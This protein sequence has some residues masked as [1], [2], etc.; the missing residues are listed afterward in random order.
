MSNLD[1]TYLRYIYDGL[2][3]GSVHLENA[4]ELPD[5]LIGLYEESFEE[6]VP[7]MHR[8]KLLQRFALFA[9]LKKEV[10]V[11]FVAEVLD[12]NEEDILDFINTYASWFNSP[13]PGK[14][15]LYHERLK[16][17]LLQ[18]LSEQEVAIL[19]DSIVYFLERNVKEEKVNESVLYCFEFLS[20]HLFFCAYLYGKKEPLAR[21]CLDD[22][23]KKRQFEI[24]GFYDWE[25]QLM[26]FGVQL[27]ALKG[28][29]ICH[30]IVF[31]KTKIQFKKKD[32]DLILSLIKR[33]K[34]SIVFRFFQT[35]QETNL[36][37]RIELAYFYIFSFYEIFE[38]KNFTFIQKK[39]IA[40]KLLEIFENNFQWD[41]GGHDL[42]EF[43]DVN[44]SFRLHCYFEQFGLNFKSIAI[45]CSS[46]S[47][48]F[49][50]DMNASF[51]E[52]LRF[53]GRNHTGEAKTILKDFKKFD[54]GIKDEKIEGLIYSEY[55]AFEL[56]EIN[57]ELLLK[58]NDFSKIQLIRDELA[59]SGCEYET[60]DELC[61]FI[62]QTLRKIDI[63]RDIKVNV[64]N[65]LKTNINVESDG[66]FSIKGLFENL[67]GKNTLE[68]VRNDFDKQNEELNSLSTFISGGFI[69]EEFLSLDIQNRYKFLYDETLDCDE[70]IKLM[71]L[72]IEL[73]EYFQKKKPIDLFSLL[74]ALLVEFHLNMHNEFI[75][76]YTN[77]LLEL[78]S[79]S[80][81]ENEEFESKFFNQLL[82][83]F[84]RRD[85]N[86]HLNNTLKLIQ[87]NLLET[88]FNF[89]FYN[90][91]FVAGCNLINLFSK[92][93]LD[94]A[95]MDIFNRIIEDL[96]CLIEENDIN[97]MW[98]AIEESCINNIYQK[99]YFW[100]FH[101]AVKRIQFELVR[102]NLSEYIFEDILFHQGINQKTV[103]FFR[104]NSTDYPEM[105]K[106][107][108]KRLSKK[109]SETN[110]FLSYLPIMEEN[111]QLMERLLQNIV[112]SREQL[113]EPLNIKILKH[114]GLDWVITLDNQYE[115]LIEN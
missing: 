25:E 115:K 56:D 6:N 74:S 44:I 31:E 114:Y 82:D 77:D 15:Q 10:S 40:T 72:L 67:D 13:E 110:Q 7:L 92:Y 95:E 109:I 66:V 83:F 78:I 21:Y 14:F 62:K 24:S 51:F 3:K 38:I 41:S 23:F 12:E 30:E 70:D 19:N 112:S 37:A 58:I 108:I 68:L 18:K 60:F 33:G 52:P 39:E 97:Q 113:K 102:E 84:N 8:Q 76:E 94:F 90:Y 104:D 99:P 69:T 93:K 55:E 105:Y 79:S 28:E 36:F 29:E 65:E 27:F 101:N 75:E 63:A 96:D 111:D 45:L 59:Y 103:L 26:Q 64:L 80:I 4:S 87:D 17:Y 100:D 73:S 20:F 71:C 61:S 50:Y 57:N 32:I 91:S 49:T 9:L 107:A 16:V 53:I 35:T 11:H 106:W 89:S 46:C 48:G 34:M 1:P 86:G 22:N 54:Y 2:I 43:V 88:Y 5:G 81:E 85:V 98:G 42:S 47:S